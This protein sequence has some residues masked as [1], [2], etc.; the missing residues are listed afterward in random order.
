MLLQME[1]QSDKLIGW[2][3][4]Q[5]GIFSTKGTNVSKE[6]RG[7]RGRKEEEKEEEVD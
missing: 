5:I 7:E 2:A 6:R 1:M 4:N 3:L